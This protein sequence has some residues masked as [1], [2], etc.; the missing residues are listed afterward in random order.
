[1]IR[2]PR[3]RMSQPDEKYRP[4]RLVTIV[5]FAGAV[6][7]LAVAGSFMAIPPRSLTRSGTGGLMRTSISQPTVPTT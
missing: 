3:Q 5:G 1:M 4:A 2:A 7:F 6:F